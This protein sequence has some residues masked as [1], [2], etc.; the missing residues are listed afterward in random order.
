M[1]TALKLKKETI[2]INLKSYSKVFAGAS[3][4]AIGFGLFIV[5]FNNTPG[6]IFGLSIAI[7]ELTGITSIGTLALCINIPILL[8]GTKILGRK[9]G[10]KTSFFMIVSSFLLDLIL[11]FTKKQ[12]IV[13]D[14]LLSAIFGGVLTGICIAIVKKAGATTGGQDII[15]RILVNKVNIDFSQLILLIDALIILFAVIVFKDFTMSAYCLVAIVATSRTI[16]YFLQQ[17]IQNKTV[18]I[19]SKKNDVLES[20][21]RKDEKINKSVVK[22]IHKDSEE[23]MILIT[24][25]NKKFSVIES[26]I[27]ETDPSAHIISLNSNL[28]LST[29]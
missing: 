3:I 16:K 13:D 24:K 1:R 10:L 5:P 14:I 8:L 26:L 17:D 29:I 11:F 15:A 23:K 6:G 27:Y 12:V 18:L 19:F 9:A 25:N 4:L 20:V 21:I 28:G 2:K 22:L 7:A